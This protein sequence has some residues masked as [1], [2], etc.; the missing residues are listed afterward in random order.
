MCD[1]AGIAKRITC[2]K[3]KDI[4]DFNNA[5]VCTKVRGMHKHS[6]SA[7]LRSALSYVGREGF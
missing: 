5:S 1:V 2:L 7:R 6:E 4:Q 3:L